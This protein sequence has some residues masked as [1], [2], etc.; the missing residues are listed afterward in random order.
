MSDETTQIRQAAAGDSGAAEALFRAYEARIYSYLFR[1]LGD[2]TEAE[3]ATQE[4]FVNAFA[5]LPRYEDR[6][7]FKAW[8]F[9]IAHREGLKRSR[10]RK[11]QGEVHLAI[12]EQVDPS[13]DVVR[14][15]QATSASDRDLKLREAIDRLP[16]AEK[17][18]VLLR[19]YS[20]LTFKEISEIM[21]AS[22]NTT[23]GRMHNALKRLRVDAKDL[24]DEM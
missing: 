21:D 24:A 12:L 19:T 18:V 4:C 13:S 23:L 11:R 14:P 10:S 5:A 17:T 6:G 7:H 22:L 2:R 20:A 3:D 1:M 8:L 15:D 9:Q 16:E